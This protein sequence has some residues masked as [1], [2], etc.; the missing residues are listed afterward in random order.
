MQC[1]ICWLGWVF[2]CVSDI[3]QACL[4]QAKFI[5]LSALYS[6]FQT[7]Q[8]KPAKPNLKPTRPTHEPKQTQP[9]KPDQKN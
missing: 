5:F 9:Y 3:T 1:A 6:K 2:V 8:F 4:W 7:R